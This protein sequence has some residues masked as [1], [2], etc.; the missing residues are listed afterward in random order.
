MSL[1]SQVVTILVLFISFCRF[2][3]PSGIFLPAEGLL[4]TFCGASQLVMN[5]FS[6]S[7][8]VKFLTSS[9]KKCGKINLT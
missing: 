4:L 1:F 9:L 6:F 5:S 8:S 7:L 2:R 3:F